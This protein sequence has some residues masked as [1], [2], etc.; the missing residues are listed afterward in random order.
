MQ[1]RSGCAYR[2]KDLAIE[3]ATV[4]YMRILST[5][6]LLNVCSFACDALAPGP[7][8][9]AHFVRSESNQDRETTKTRNRKIRNFRKIANRGAVEWQGLLEPHGLIFLLIVISE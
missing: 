4:A 8:R 5:I 1:A 9:R 6:W 7:L 2:D 3:H